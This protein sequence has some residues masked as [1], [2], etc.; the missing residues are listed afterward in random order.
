MVQTVLTVVFQ[1]EAGGGNPCPV[2]LDADGLSKEEL[3]KMTRDFGEESAFLMR[4]TDPQCD[5]KVRYFVP[6]H[7][8]EMCV[9]ATIAS[10][11]VL[12]RRGLISASP[13][14]FEAMLGRVKAHWVRRD[15]GQIDVGVGQFL[16]RFME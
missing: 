8:M 16:P 2:T 1:A 14:T 6:I 11:A 4:P 15:D 13:L 5:V 7:K 12:V 3:Q 9:H 10:T